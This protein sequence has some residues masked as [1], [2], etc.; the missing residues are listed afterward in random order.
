MSQFL[1]HL[2][3]NSFPTYNW[4]SDS[5]APTVAVSPELVFD[6]LAPFVSCF[7]EQ[8]RNYFTFGLAA[9]STVLNAA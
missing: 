6:C 4:L 9:D 8:I 7:D 2:K 3:F 1:T 5:P